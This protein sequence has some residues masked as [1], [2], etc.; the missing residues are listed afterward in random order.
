MMTLNLHSYRSQPM[1]HLR[2]FELALE[3]N[4]QSHNKT[5]LFSGQINMAKV[6]PPNPKRFPTSKSDSIHLFLFA[7]A[8]ALSSLS[9]DSVAITMA[10]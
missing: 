5:T 9:R 10:R 8:E 1:L 4:V 3:K 7:W 2:W 6:A